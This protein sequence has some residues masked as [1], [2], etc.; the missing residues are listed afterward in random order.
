LVELESK[1][2]NFAAKNHVTNIQLS[3]RGIKLFIDNDAAF[4]QLKKFLVDSNVEFFT[5]TLAEDQCIKIVLYGL[6]ELDLEDLKKEL[7]EQK[8]S[9]IDIKKL[10]IRNMRYDH[11]CHYLLYFKKSDK[12]KI[13]TLREIK[14]IFRIIVRWEYYVHK[15]HGPTQCSN[16]QDFSHGTQNCYLK[17]KCIRCS[18]DHKSSDCPLIDKENPKAKTPDTVLK[19]ANCSGR[20]VASYSLC[21]KRL[22][23]IKLRET[24]KNK[25]SSRQRKS[26]NFSFKE[27]PQLDNINFPFLSQSRHPEKPAW[28][29]R[30]HNTNSSKNNFSNIGISKSGNDLLSAEECFT[31]FNEF[32]NALS[33]CNSRMDQLRVIGE[34]TLK[35]LSK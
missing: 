26:T 29:N 1:L 13:S 9:P 34:I 18:L 28:Q 11:Q 12:I 17:P 10:K 6:P 15:R 23:V 27:A 21:P 2:E 7:H 19:C 35:Y 3:Q 5:H 4:N 33:K 16:C 22:E 8:L 20:H 25:N 31:V 30:I 24:F 14:A 32:L